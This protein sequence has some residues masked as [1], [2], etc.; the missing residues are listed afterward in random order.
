MAGSAAIDDAI[1]QSADKLG[2]TLKEK[3]REAL[4]GFCQGNDVFVCL[5]TGYGKSLI[6]ALLPLVFNV[7]N[8]MIAN[9][10]SVMI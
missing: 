8:G 9:T 6:Y 5:P 7:L 3:Q 1:T 10:F 2:V 4:H